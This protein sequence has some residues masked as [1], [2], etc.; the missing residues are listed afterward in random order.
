MKSRSFN[1][2]DKACAFRDKVDGITQWMSYKGEYYWI[3]WW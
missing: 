3:V 1:N 2:Y